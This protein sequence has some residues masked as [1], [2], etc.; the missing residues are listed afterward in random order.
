MTVTIVGL[1]LMGGSAAIDLKTK[2]FAKRIIGGDNNPP[3]RDMALER[4]LVDDVMSL[5]SGINEADL[6]ILAI[7][8]DAI[9][10]LLPFVLDS[11]T[12]QA[13]TDM[14]SSQS[15]IV[16]A[17][18]KHP[19]RGNYVASHPMAG[20]EFSGPDAAIPHLFSKKVGIICDM[21]DSNSKALEMVTDFYMAL[22]MRLVFMNSKD[23]DLH[24]AY[25]SHISHLTSFALAL[26]VLDKEQNEKNI[27]N[28][29]SGGFDSTVRLAAS[30]AS[31]WVPIFAQN[32]ENVIE[33]MD[34]YIEKMTKFKDAI[35]EGNDDIVTSL[36]EEAN[37]IQKTLIQFS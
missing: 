30:S 37:I 14:G 1:G 23:H 27:F 35:A 24:A 25:V 12:S 19:R 6:I 5:Q 22:N 34:T 36:I 4:G 31:M 15:E 29:A 3:H 26:T 33:V 9:K 13:V 20:T 16:E 8:V 18:R 11:I 28:L 17:I 2:R 21:A 10:Q 7:P 32:R